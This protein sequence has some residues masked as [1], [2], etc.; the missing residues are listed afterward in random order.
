M[1]MNVLNKI[2]KVSICSIM[3]ATMALTGMSIPG[4]N[5]NTM[6]VAQ[7][8]TLR[9]CYLVGTSNVRTYSDPAL[10][11]PVG[12]IYPSDLIVVSNVTGKYSYGYYPVGG[13]KVKYAYFATSAILIGT[14]GNTYTN[15]VGSFS[16][17]VRPG[18]AQFG[19]CT[20]GDK[21]TVLGVS[22]NYTQIKYPVSG[23][24]FKYAFALTSEVNRCLFGNTNSIVASGNKKINA[25]Q[26]KSVMFN[27]TYY[28]NTYSDLKAAF[29]Y[30]ANKLY[31]H[32]LTY[33]IKEGRTASP[34]FDPIFYLNNNDDLKRAFGSNNYVVAYNHW[35]EHGCSEGRASSK[36]YNGYYYRCK[37]GDLQNAF[38][39][40]G[41]TASAYVNLADHYLKHGITE[42]RWGNSSGYIPGGAGQS[43]NNST[44]VANNTLGAPVP[45]GCKFSKQ[46][47]DG[48]WYGYH[49]INRGVSTLTPVYALC[50][51]KVTYKQAYTTFSGVKKLTSYGNY[52]E[53]T[54]AN[55]V[56]TAKYCHLSRFV[57]ANQI[58]SSSNTVRK[59]GSSGTY[60]ITTRN[61][62]KG[63]IIGYIGTT[64]NS[65]GVHLHFELRK[66]GSR[67]NPT[68]LI[69]GLV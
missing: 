25:T 30:D 19:T 20:K 46:T 67:I 23:G 53:F 6:I 43:S 29:G 32:Y 1:R 14:T 59:S 9:Q 54:S 34:I 52:I 64:G 33:G 47:Q 22:G 21:V 61:V 17:F 40:G 35:I 41:V 45:A 66:T 4:S 26:A 3:A 11:K 10:T 63:E 62:N 68:S 42:R 55:N 60:T 24:K 27:A 37:Y 58:I 44:P 36:Y 38:F 39:S 18:G 57:G 8:A 15:N 5:M 16:T 2:A 12:W 7:A 65:S 28:A 13:G 49:D 50:D 51:G 56:Y 69:G 31:N 48:S